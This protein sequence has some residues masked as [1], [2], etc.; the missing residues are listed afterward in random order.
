MGTLKDDLLHA[1]A[2][3]GAEGE[4]ELAETHA[5]WVFLVGGEV[6]KVKKPVDFGFLDFCT[7]ERR[8]AAC[9]AEVSLNARL[10]PDVYLGVLPVRRD[11]NG[12]H[13][14]NG[15]GE[16]VDWAVHMVRLPDE[17]RADQRLARGALSGADVDAIA[18]RIADFH[19]RARHD[20]ATASFGTAD[21]VGWSVRENFAQT[22][23]VVER[24][25]DPEDARD[26]ERWQTDFLR[27]HT[28]LF[29]ARIAAG[30]VRDGHGDLRL[31]HVYLRP[32]GITI[33]DCIEFNE[34]FR[35]ADVCADLAFLSMDLAYAGRADL[36]ERLLARYAR[37]TNDFD[38]YALVDFYESYRAYVRAKVS[39]M[40]AAD[41]G[42]DPRLRAKASAEARRYFLLALSADRRP[43]LAPAL[44]CVGGIIASGKS[45]IAAQ[46][47]EE[48]DAPVVEAD[49][50]RK[51][52][53]GV[54]PRTPVHDKAWKGA[55]D[56]GFTEQVYAEVRRRAR[57]VLDSGRPVVMD[58]S[59]RSRPMRAAARALAEEAGV[60]F[61]F[62]ECRAD[63][64]ICRERLVRRRRETG[65]SDGRLEIFEDFCARVEP[66]TE[67]GARDHLVLDTSLPLEESVAALRERLAVW[68]R[69]LGG[70]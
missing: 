15:P 49:R 42:A 66:V 33:I 14:V 46:I 57:V 32:Q 68:P 41:E 2:F 55:Y 65:V 17:Q 53:I 60:P 1:G 11:R 7:R 37:D 35:F 34:R 12:V 25:V 29:D 59:F 61:L 69:G 51:H 20:Q 64:A 30:R 70:P 52:M 21:A 47:A 36:A 62:V 40:L 5:S 43:L 48:L 26:I 19:E 31:E 18:A 54:A 58:A 28:A 10:A 63:A 27:E 8:R 3:P 9:E 4:I 23:G 16:T 39:L 6:F 38:L 50:T 44:V 45:T 67:L 22:R 56:P 24:S 13:S